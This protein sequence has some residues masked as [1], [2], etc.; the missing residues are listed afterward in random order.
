MDR[1]LKQAIGPSENAKTNHATISVPVIWKYS[2]QQP[3]MMT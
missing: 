1:R 2:F 3:G